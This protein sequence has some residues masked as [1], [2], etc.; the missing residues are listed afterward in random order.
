MRKVPARALGREGNLCLFNLEDDIRAKPSPA[1]RGSIAG[2]QLSAPETSG[3][4]PAK[5]FGAC[6]MPEALVS[7]N[8][9]RLIV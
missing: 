9:T 4:V 7:K 6:T 3:T 5:G 1:R 2:S 8:Q